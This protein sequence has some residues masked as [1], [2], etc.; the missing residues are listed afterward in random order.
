MGNFVVV[1]SLW[2]HRGIYSYNLLVEV[3]IAV[4]L[5]DVEILDGM[6]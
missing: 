2:D 1:S 5:S 4:T 6:V 3:F